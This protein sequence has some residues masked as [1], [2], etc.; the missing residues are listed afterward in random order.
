MDR[1]FIEKMNESVREFER[2]LYMTRC[3]D[4]Q[5]NTIS[6]IAQTT[7]EIAREKEH[8]VDQHDEEYAN[9]LLG[10]Q[11]VMGALAAELSMYLALK[12]QKPDAAWDHLV[13][14]QGALAAAG[15]ASSGFRHL[16]VR[17]DRLIAIEK[18]IFPPQAFLS[19]GM[20]VV[21]A[22]CSICN[23]DYADCNHVTGFPYMGKFCNTVITEVD[24]DHV[25]IVEEPA[26]KR[27]R[28]TTHSSEDEG[29][30]WMTL[31]ME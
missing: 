16:R 20:T 23:D 6:A 9:I 21:Q 26:D 7:D 3:S 30:N 25:A 4:L 12:E 18:I 17:Y 31:R 1:S 8:A 10:F 13:E 14:A 29:R 15:R 22:E 2:F 19:A 24:L 5:R 27:C 11:C 28:V